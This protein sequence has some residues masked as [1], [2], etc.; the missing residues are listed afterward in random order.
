MARSAPFALIIDRSIPDLLKIHSDTPLDISSDGT[1]PMAAPAVRSQRRKK[2]D[3][4]QE[5]THKRYGRVFKK[6]AE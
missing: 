1:R 3:A 5:W 6:L 4:A 2:F